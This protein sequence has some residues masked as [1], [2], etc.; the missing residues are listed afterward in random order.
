MQD[1]HCGVRS[2]VRLGRLQRRDR[3][4]LSPWIAER[5]VPELHATSRRDQFDCPRVLG[6]RHWRIQYLEHPLE[7]DEC[8]Q[9][10]ESGV[11]QSREWLVDALDEG[12]HRH[13][14]A[15]GDSPIDDHERSN[16]VDGH[17]SEGSDEAECDEEHSAI[18]RRLHTDVAHPRRARRERSNLF[19]PPAE[20]LDEQCAGNVEAL[21][22]L[23]VH[24]GIQPH[25]LARDVLQADAD[26]TRGNDE[27]RE[28]DE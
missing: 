15:D 5:H 12:G 23:R 27:R 19:R 4:V 20:Q 28:H 22:H 2:R 8:G 13:E 11:R 16:A 10:F 1:V 18:H 14:G 9:H 24:L 17:C 25:L 26:A 21:G 7:A 6:D 3:D